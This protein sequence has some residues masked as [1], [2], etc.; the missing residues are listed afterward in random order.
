MTSG[1]PRWMKSLYLHRQGKDKK[2]NCPGQ[3]PL[4][5]RHWWYYLF[6]KRRL[7]GASS[8]PLL[9]LYDSRQKHHALHVSS[10]L[11]GPSPHSQPQEKRHRERGKTILEYCCG[12]DKQGNQEA[13]PKKAQMKN[14]RFHSLTVELENPERENVSTDHVHWSICWTNTS[15]R[16]LFWAN[17]CV[18][19]ARIKHKSSKSSSL[20]P[21]NLVEEANQLADRHHDGAKAGAVKSRMPRCK[22]WLAPSLT[23]GTAVRKFSIYLCPSFIICKVDVIMDY[24]ELLFIKRNYTC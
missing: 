7:T 24:K 9:A 14:V 10:L 17:L 18:K 8:I 20:M 3:K 6:M 22:P 11:T 19:A 12:V 15:S 16:H 21:Y 4:E 2:Q 13:H 23:S 1:R 5:S